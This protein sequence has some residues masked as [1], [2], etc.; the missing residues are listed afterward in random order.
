[1]TEGLIPA[2]AGAAQHG[3][4]G[5]TGAGKDGRIGIGLIGLGMA[6]KPHV[7]AL[8]LLADRVDLVAGF[9]PSAERRAA[10]EAAWQVPTVATEEALLA[11]PRVDAVLVLTPPLTHD[12]IARRALAAGKH[13][14]L[15]KPLT[16]DA[17]S[18]TALVEAFEAAGRK[19][20]VVFQHRFREAPM[21]LR[22]ALA[23][24]RLGDLKSVSASIRWWRSF[25]YFAEPGRGMKARDGG[26]VLLTQAIHT[27]DL[28]LDLAGPITDVSARCV[29]SGLRP[30]DT[31]DIACAVTRFDNG[32]VGVIDATTLAWPGYPERIELAGTRGAACLAGERLQMQVHGEAAEEFV[33]T[34]GGGGGADPMAFAADAHRRL[35]AE[36]VDAI[37]AGRTPSNSGRSALGVQRLIDAM[38]ASS[39]SGQTV[40]LDA[41]PG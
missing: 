8:K 7:A 19:L 31:E 3:A 28:M 30:I 32:A 26:G 12:A 33:G 6:V 1:M 40:R 5:M 16:A 36:F 14:L 39:R 35:I 9:S 20:G 10:F 22:A 15:E 18:A 34:D 25:E 24:G 29:T 37:K 27:L 23:A 13:V 21:A 11:D 38:L 41:L 4:A 17:T 2:S